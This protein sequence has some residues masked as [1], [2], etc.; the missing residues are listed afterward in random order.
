MKTKIK[1][2]ITLLFIVILGGITLVACGGSGSDWESTLDEFEAWVNSAIEEI[3]GLGIGGDIDWTD[4]DAIEEFYDRVEEILEDQEDWEERLGDILDEL[5]EA[6][7]EEALEK[8]NS[9]LVEIY[10]RL[11]EAMF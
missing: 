1:R 3:E 2:G 7:D 5:E 10:T 4:F 11:M 6:E 8:F 9:R